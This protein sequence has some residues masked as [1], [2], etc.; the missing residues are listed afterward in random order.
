MSGVP[1]SWDETNSGADAGLIRIRLGITA[2]LQRVWP[3]PWGSQ[4]CWCR[5]TLLASRSFIGGP[6]GSNGLVCTLQ[7]TAHLSAFIRS[8]VPTC[9]A[10]CAWRGGQQADGDRN[11][12]RQSSTSYL[13][14]EVQCSSNKL[15]SP[16]PMFSTI[17]FRTLTTR[18][19]WA[20][21]ASA[22][23]PSRLLNHAS[24]APTGHHGVA[25]STRPGPPAL[26][27]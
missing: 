18:P 21:S 15:T 5:R 27:A 12:L 26:R 1:A 19:A 24:A 16:G 2:R 10:S 20:C 9:D 14:E 6:T 11:R 7:S 4:P 22:P 23:G 17:P 8:R 13:Y 25:A 3:W